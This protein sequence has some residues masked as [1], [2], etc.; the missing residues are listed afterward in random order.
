MIGPGRRQDGEPSAGAA[1]CDGGGLFETLPDPAVEYAVEDGRPA[2]TAANP[3]YRD[4]FGG[5]PVGTPLADRLRADLDGTVTETP[6]DGPDSLSAVLDAAAAGRRC[7]AT[8][9]P[10]HDDERG[11]FL[12]RVVPA[13]RGPGG[14]LTL[15]DVTDRHERI[16]SLVAERDRL[17]EFASIVS[18]DL[19]NPLEVA[20]I[21]LDAAERTGE[22]AHFRKAEAAHD[23]MEQI[24]EDVLTLARRGDVIDDV[25][26]VGLGAVARAAWGTVSADG[27]SLSVADDATVEA[28]G[29]RLQELLENL[30]RNAV[31]H[32]GPAVG[33]TVGRTDGGFYVADDGPGV[34]EG[35]REKVFEPGVSTG[36]DGT[37]LGLPIVKRIA[38]AHGWDVALASAEDGGAR[39]EFTGVSIR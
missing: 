19:R 27:A 35:D 11:A 7:R 26:A 3:A 22:E 13:A 10:A 6:F 12:L 32:A 25:E 23:R 36:E 17:D 15:T 39:F 14:F 29:D 4:T 16:R 37:G 8:V 31:E 20:R 21:R 33:I 18:H 28:D 24:I 38:A 9:R 34:P 1:R 2:V 5:D 30:F